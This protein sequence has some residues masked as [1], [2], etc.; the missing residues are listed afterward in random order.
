MFQAA[1]IPATSRLNQAGRR[2]P[3]STSARAANSKAAEQSQVVECT[4]ILCRPCH[5]LQFS[6]M[7]CLVHARINT[8]LA[9]C[10]Y[11]CHLCHLCHLCGHLFSYPL[12]CVS[13]PCL[14]FQ[15]A[16][17]P[18]TSRSNRAGRREA[19]STSAR[20]TN[21]AAAKQSKVLDTYHQP[22]RCSGLCVYIIGS[23][24]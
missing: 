13:Y 3:A 14:M 9:G 5:I 10:S 18:T 24:R 1:S 11:L 19:A 12:D 23:P 2:V 20:A 4:E 17:V 22:H 21:S 15:A 7:C 8:V 6:G 16:S